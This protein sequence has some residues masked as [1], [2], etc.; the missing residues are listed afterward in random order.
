MSFLSRIDP[1]RLSP[2]RIW[3]ALGPEVKRAGAGALVRSEDPSD[4]AEAVAAIAERMKFRPASVRKLPADKRIEYLS[5]AIHPDDALASS[6][7]LALHLAERRPLLAAFLTELG[8]END[9]GMIPEG[10]EPAPPS[11]EAL[12]KAATVLFERFAPEDV[13][14][15]LATLAVMDGQ[16]WGGI[17]AV[18]RERKGSR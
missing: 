13:E 17:P 2:S 7:L 8:I 11:E 10:E 16:L 4:R 3:S 18:L 1:D 12:G 15:Y 14:V 9:D 5:R 6:L